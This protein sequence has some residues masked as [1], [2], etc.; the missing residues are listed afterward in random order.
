MLLYSGKPCQRKVP[1]PAILGRRKEV[2]L[3]V[4]MVLP[5]FVQVQRHPLK[6][7]QVLPVHQKMDHSWKTRHGAG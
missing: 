3:P 1:S 6:Q 2:P 7:Y 4:P 5:Y